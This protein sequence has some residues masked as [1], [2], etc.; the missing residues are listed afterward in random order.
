MSWTATRLEKGV[1][2]GPAVRLSVDGR[3]I[4]AFA[5]ESVGAALLA[6]GI[7]AVRESPSAHEPRGLFCGMGVSFECLV[8]IDGRPNQRACLTAVA[9]GMHVVTR[10]A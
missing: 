8:Q 3:E 1:R 5:G 9:D 4:G 6:A 2:R 7:R 10:R